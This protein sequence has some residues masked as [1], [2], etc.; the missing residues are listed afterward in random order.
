MPGGQIRDPG[1]FAW[2]A[3]WRWPAAQ[4][5]ALAL[6]VLLA[7]TAFECFGP[8]SGQTIAWSSYDQMQQRRLWASAP[9]PRLLIADI[10]ERSLAEM[11][12]EFGRWPWPRDTLASV[13]AHAEAA[14]A[15]AVVFDILFADADR[16]HPG[17]DAAFEAAV[18]QSRNSFFPVVRL[19][20]SL[21]ATSKLSAAH[22]P[23]LVEPGAGPAPTLALIVPFMRAML[24]SGR[25]GTHTATLDGDGK[26]RRFALAEPLDDGGRLLS[27]PAAVARHLGVAAAAEPAPRLIV[28]R[29]QAEAYPRVPFSVLWQ[30]AEGRVRDDCPALAGRILV[31]GASAPSLHDIKTT[32]LA[33]HHMGVDILATLIDNALHQRAYRELAPALRW[34]LCVA[35]LALAA[36][37]VRRGAA[38]ATSRALWL[39]PLTLL[40]IAYASLHSEHGYL[41]LTLPATAA[42]AFLS[43]VKAHDTLR[44][45]GFGRERGSAGPWAVACGTGAAEAERL[46]RAAF[47][48][49]L[50]QGLPISGSSS[51]SGDAGAGHAVWT[52][53]RLPDAVAAGSAAQTLC[54][55]VP[56]AWATQFPVGPAPERDLHQSLA[57]A[58]PLSTP[59]PARA[60]G[61]PW[62][63]GKPA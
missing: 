50:T 3:P 49:A 21:D 43:A 59:S 45:S 54:D 20:R 51:V 23:G 60:G 28:W 56:G 27:I 25:L 46:E 47:D 42:L 38:G 1:R 61:P 10:D 15:K 13:L 8:A 53:W 4:A 32:P 39:L 63:S 12:P 26:I 34:A 22:L 14:G 55:A 7:W 18:R 11:A 41:D 52:I 5:H 57:L 17:G 30:C 37:V 31:V 33:T 48:F 19:P 36:S 29:R 24:D 9:D 44:R 40:A 62:G 16:L 6:A 2:L 58:L 35:A